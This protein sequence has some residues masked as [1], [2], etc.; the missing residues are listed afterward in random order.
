MF[1]KGFWITIK[2]Y[3]KNP[4]DKVSFGFFV[5]LSSSL[6]TETEAAYDNY[7]SFYWKSSIL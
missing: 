7:K 1:E 2:Q 5:C 4:A 3:L 6:D